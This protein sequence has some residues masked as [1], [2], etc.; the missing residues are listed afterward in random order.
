MDHQDEAMDLLHHLRCMDQDIMDH[1]II[2]DQHIMDLVIITTII[3]DVMF[4]K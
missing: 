1:A 3:G 2:M 4:S